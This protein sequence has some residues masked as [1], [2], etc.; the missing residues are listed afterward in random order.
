MGKIANKWAAFR[1][2]VQNDDT[3][4]RARH[5]IA[6]GTKALPPATGRYL[7]QKVPVVQ[8]LPKYS[9]AWLVG[10]LIA[11]I[12]VGVLLI[13]QGLAFA[14]LAGLPMQVGLLASWFP[15]ALYLFQGT[16]KGKHFSI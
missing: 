8:W 14:S 11:G 2:G 6:R 15:S 13:P 10:D 4:I 16:S 9:K 1:E 12:T 7:T 5:G 3:L